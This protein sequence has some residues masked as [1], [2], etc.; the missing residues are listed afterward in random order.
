M[1]VDLSPVAGRRRLCAVLKRAREDQNL[2]QQQV[3]TAMDWS[4]SKLIRIENGA[5]GIS[6]TD[7]RALLWH[8]SVTDTATIGELMELARTGRRRAWWKEYRDHFVTPNLGRLI[9]LEFVASRLKIFNPS[10]LPGLMQTEDYARAVLRTMLPPPT[11]EQL[12]ARVRVRLRRQQELLRREEP[13]NI[14]AVLDEAVLRRST[15]DAA[16]MREQLLRLL[17]LASLP[18]VTIEILPFAAGVFQLA[19]PFFIM[20]FPNDPDV[21]YIE[22][23]LNEDLIEGNDRSQDYQEAFNAIREYSLRSAESRALIEK[24]ASELR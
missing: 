10:I 7:L 4:L 6:T 2:T 19:G 1:A 9:D 12:E 18:N 15:G 17:E 14:L 8:Y 11:P 23:S 22:S 21:V 13:P 24:V 16:S 20:S 3:A 5:V